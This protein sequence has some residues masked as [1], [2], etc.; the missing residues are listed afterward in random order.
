LDPGTAIDWV[1]VSGIEGN[2]RAYAPA[3]CCYLDYEVP[4]LPGAIADSNGCA[5]GRALEDAIGRGLLELVERDATGIWWYGMHRRQALDPSELRDARL[6]EILSWHATTRRHLQI[7]DLASDLSIPV[8]AC[9]STDRDGGQVALGFGASLD[10]MEAAASSVLEML[11][12]E[13]SMSLI[14]TA[15]RRTSSPSTKDERLLAAWKAL[16]STTTCPQLRSVGQTPVPSATG[17]GPREAVTDTIRRKL[18]RA[19]LVGWVL[20]VSRDDLPV[21]VVRILVPGLCHYKARLGARRLYE[22]PF[23]LGWTRQ[24]VSEQELN[25]VPLL[26]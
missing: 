25:P 16:V 15:K 1:Q 5:A 3:A 6:R 13:L 8:Y 22:V 20:D 12:L 2:E 23:E 18:T 11:Q 17:S 9:V 21:H 24:P 26:I 19:G 14:A 7:L 10:P 4:P